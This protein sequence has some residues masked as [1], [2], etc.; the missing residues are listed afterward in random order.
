MIAM[1]FYNITYSIAAEDLLLK[2][3][4]VSIPTSVTFKS[5][6]ETDSAYSATHNI[7][8]DIL[9]GNCD[10]F[11]LLKRE[12]MQASSYIEDATS[13][14]SIAEYDGI[15]YALESGIEKSTVKVYGSESKELLFDFPCVSG[16][17]IGTVTASKQYVA[18]TVTNCGSLYL[19]DTC[20][21][22]TSTLLLSGV[23]H[24]AP[25]GSLVVI[26]DDSET[27]SKYKIEDGELIKLWTCKDNFEYATAVC[28]DCHGLI[29]VFTAPHYNS[30][31]L[32]VLCP[33]GM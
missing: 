10:G 21:K 31:S 28:T 23:I 24:F 12:T 15:V 29:Y 33:Q 27:L 8:G 18:A 25:D 1:L 14:E 17:N 6:H 2:F 26:E 9:M 20:N 5:S 11:T 32:D 30:P 4:V 16:S 13:I 7:N 3:E 22:Q 19:Y